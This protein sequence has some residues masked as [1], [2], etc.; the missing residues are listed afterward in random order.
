MDG[1]EDIIGRVLNGRLPGAN[2]ICWICDQV[3]GIL[4]CEDNVVR[5][6][7]PVNVCGDLRGYFE[8]LLE[9]L[10]VGG[11]PGE[12][13]YVFLGNYIGLGK[14]SINI[15]CLLFLYKIKYPGKVC[16]LRGNYETR[17]M[18]AGKKL[19]DEC[20]NKFC[21]QGLWEAIV[22][23]FMYLPLACLIDDSIFC[24]H[25]GLSPTVTTI[26]EINKIERFTE[27]TRKLPPEGPVC[28]FL[29]TIPKE[30]ESEWGFEPLTYNFSYGSK[31]SD[32]FKAE[33][34]IKLIVRSNCIVK[35]GYDIMHNGNLITIFSASNHLGPYINTGAILQVSENLETSFIQFEV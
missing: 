13:N 25:C 21:G 22:D 3:K 17:E 31:V 7:A 5:I 14:G 18:A 15:F 20:E 8:C 19:A 6:R 34:G 23:V 24:V 28:E 9:V 12:V 26:D 2:E 30:A 10:R 27:F 4:R 35:Q 29:M 32:L 16:L 33:N 11:E 1:L